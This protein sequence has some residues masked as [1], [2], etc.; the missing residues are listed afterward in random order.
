M[1]T[2]M[3]YLVVLFVFIAIQITRMLGSKNR[4]IEAL[5]FDIKDPFIDILVPFALAF[6]FV[7]VFSQ[8]FRV[9]IIA[10]DYP[11][12]ILILYIGLL[13]PISEE[14]IFRGLLIGVPLSALG[15]KREQ[16][17]IW[18]SAILLNS[19]FFAILHNNPTF[20]SFILRC[21]LG[22][23]CGAIYYLKDKNILP[24]FVFH[25]TYNWILIMN[26]L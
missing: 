13:A 10:S 25:I 7:S 4:L 9:H 16:W 23:I 18:V 2:I 24:S 26:K 11:L 6:V 17:D 12:H 21:F 14:I 3:V 19:L 5:K 8:V 20:L 15:I 1:N 22:L